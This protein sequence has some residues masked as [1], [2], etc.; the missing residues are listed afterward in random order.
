MHKTI[1]FIRHGESTANAGGITMEHST[2][3]LSDKGLQQAQAIANTLKV[4]PTLVLASEFIRTHQ[5]AQPFCTKH[6]MALQ[7]QPWL[8]EFSAISHELITGM[9]GTQRRPIADAYWAEADVN[10][11]MGKLADTFLEFNQ[12]VS[13][14][15]A[16]MA[17]LPNQTVIFGHG[18]WLGL[19]IWRLLGFD[20]QDSN[21]MKAFRRFQNSLPM[22]NGV[23]YTLSSQNHQAWTVQLAK[24][25][26]HQT[27]S[28]TPQGFMKTLE[29]LALN[30]LAEIRA[31]ES[32]IRV[33]LSDI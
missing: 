5:T 7:V 25:P 22:H 29:D 4:E 15:M 16:E 24:S 26:P 14:F 20:Y 13:Q 31:N 23:I 12:R 30:A 21:S 3:P 8:N 6:Q 9:T 2:I 10:Q 18:I 1:Y 19:L 27:S 11:R 28:K 32:V 33:S 17:H